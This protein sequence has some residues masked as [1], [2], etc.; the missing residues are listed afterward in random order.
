[1]IKNSCV[2]LHLRMRGSLHNLRR[3]TSFFIS[4][5]DGVSNLD[6]GRIQWNQVCLFR[7][8]EG[9]MSLMVDKKNI[10]I[11]ILGKRL[12]MK[13]LMFYKRTASA[14]IFVIHDR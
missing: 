6:Q 11:Y 5:V 13:L 4:S 9:P 8:V 12:R 2:F 7:G 1:M 14:Y 10:K 3:T